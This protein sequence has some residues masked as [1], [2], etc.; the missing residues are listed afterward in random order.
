[1]TPSLTRPSANLTGTTEMAS[2]F[3]GG[4]GEREERV[5]RML[6]YP[7]VEIDEELHNTDPVIAEYAL[8]S[9][10]YEFMRMPVQ[11]NA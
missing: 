6:F 3:P 11:G 2:E 10:V 9:M 7:M 1:M 5:G 8:E 4:D